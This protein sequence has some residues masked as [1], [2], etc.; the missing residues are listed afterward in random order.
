ML[1]ETVGDALCHVR[2]AKLIVPL[3]CLAPGIFHSERLTFFWQP[4]DM[5][6][7]AGYAFPCNVRGLSAPLVRIMYIGRHHC[8]TVYWKVSSSTDCVVV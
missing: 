4:R 2:E 7:A 6:S 3:Y 8:V 1:W 5:S